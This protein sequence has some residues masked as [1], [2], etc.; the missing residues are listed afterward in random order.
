MDEAYRKAPDVRIPML[1]LYGA[2]DQVIPRAPI[3]R[4]IERLKGPFT[5]AYY[6]QGYHM[7]MRDLRAK[8][9]LSDVA[10][11]IENRYRA[12]PSGHD[13]GWGDDL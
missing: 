1:L 10:S 7:L 9:V 11:W 12:L 2:K 6:P 3:R 8:T 4:I 5:V 13:S